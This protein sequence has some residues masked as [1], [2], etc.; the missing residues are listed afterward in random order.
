MNRLL[1]LLV[2]RT[3]W[4]IAAL[5]IAAGVA[6]VPAFRRDATYWLELSR[7]EFFAVAAL[8]LAMMPIILTG[9]IDLSVGSVSAFAGVVI[10]A[11]LQEAHW[12]LGWALAAGVLAGLVAGLLNAGLVVIGVM[13][14]VATLATRELF[15][16]L[17]KTLVGG[18]TG[19]GM[20]RTLTR[21]WDTPVLGVPWQLLALT[22][23]ALVT[24]LVVHHTWFGRMIYA[25]GDNEVA[26]R[27][28]GLPVTRLK[29]VL[30]AWCGLVSGW[31]GAALVMYYG[32]AT[33]NAG[34]SLELTAIACVVLGGV[35]ILGGSGG[36]PGTLLGTLTVAVLWT[37]LY[38]QAPTWRD[39]V[40][41]GL[42]ILIAVVN[43][44]ARRWA[45]RQVV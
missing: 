39:T 35:S 41:G 22:G 4:L 33:A 20:P 13:P 37:S 42:I 28:A 29:V 32:S 1:Q 43:E 10:G 36:V 44:A 31:C 12:P 5:V 27:F 40:L 24:Y 15:L 11:L 8:A 19:F 21:A 3:A 16:G 34:Q 26:A 38:L 18:T 7:Q 14:L 2:P 25:V 30:Y 6:L 17:A 9:G 23:L 45:A